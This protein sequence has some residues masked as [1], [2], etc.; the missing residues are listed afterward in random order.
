LR[1][2]VFE[3]GFHLGNLFVG[4]NPFITMDNLIKQRF[5]FLRAVK[6]N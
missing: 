1:I 4:L 2:S 3:F 6:Q 5:I